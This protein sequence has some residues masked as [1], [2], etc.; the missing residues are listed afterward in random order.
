[1]YADYKYYT[2]VYGGDAS[3]DE[4]RRYAARASAY[5]DYYT[6]GRAQAC[7]QLDGVKMACCALAELYCQI[8]TAKKTAA[9]GIARSLSSD[10]EIKSETVGSYSVTYEGGAESASKAAKL[11]AESEQMLADTARRYLAGTGLLYRG[12]W[13]ACTHRTP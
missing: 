8:E 7:P 10:G 6:F 5:I 9:A 11:A 2:E 13:S 1:M 4:F 12:R 3:E